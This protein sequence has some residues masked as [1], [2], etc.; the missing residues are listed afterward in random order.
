MKCNVL[1]RLA[2]AV[3]LVLLLSTVGCGELDIPTPG[4]APSPTDQAEPPAKGDDQPTTGDESPATGGDSPATGDG[5]PTT[6]G[7]QPTT[8]DDSPATGGDQPTT[9]DDSPA[10]GDQPAPDTQKNVFGRASFTSDGHLLIADR[11]YLSLAEYPNVPSAIS[12]TPNVAGDYAASYVEGG[13][14]GWRIPTK[15]DAELLRQ[16]LAF[17]E[18]PFYGADIIVK[19]NNFLEDRDFTG[20]YREEYLCDD[21]LTTFNFSASGV[22]TDVGKT[23]LYKLR[24]VRD[25]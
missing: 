19:L 16:V 23:K 13:L 3:S 10:T 14:K 8:G 21:A 11:L 22:Y 7:N 17:I 1:S 12:A 15:T 6:G 18:S 5:Q 2:A 24:F 20:I 25:K 9:S 4:E